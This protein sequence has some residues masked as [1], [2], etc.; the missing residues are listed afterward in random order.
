M[1]KTIGFLRNK[2]VIG[3]GLGLAAAVA[4]YKI[5]KSKKIRKTLVR[6]VVCGM[7]LR[8]D[9]KFTLNTIKEEAEDI[10]AEAQE[11]A[12][13]ERREGAGL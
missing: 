8:D 10:R 7:K 1:E 2:Y 9:A 4:G 13:G 11:Q 3:F 5:Y 6:A 12:A